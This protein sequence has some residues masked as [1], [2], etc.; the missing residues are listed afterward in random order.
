[1]RSWAGIVLGGSLSW[2]PA[3]EERVRIEGGA[4]RVFLTQDR[5]D[6]GEVHQL[7]GS[8]D[9][10]SWREAAISNA[11][12]ARY[13][14]APD[15]GVSFYRVRSRPADEASDWTNQLG[16]LD[17]RIFTESGGLPND[18][19]YA[20][21][22][23]RLDEPGRVYFQDSDRYPFH[24]DFVRARLPG[25]QDIG[26]Q[27]YERIS[28]HPEGQELLVGTV[29]RPPD[30][31]LTELGIQFTGNEPF[32]IEDVARWFDTVHSRILAPDGWRFFY[33]PAYEQSATAFD[34]EAWFAERGI[35]VDSATRW[36]TEN[37]CYSDGWALGRLKFFSAGDID[38]AFGD[39]RLTDRDIL[40]TDQ[41][42]AEIPLV[43]GVLTL[44]PATPNSH[45]AIQAKGFRIPFAHP[46]GRALQD[47]IL[48]MDGREVLLVVSVRDGQCEVRV[49]D[50]E[51]RL[52]PG[53]REAILDSKQAPDVEIVPMAP[54]GTYHLEC[55]GLTPD[56][57]GLVGG[58]AANF[59]F[60]RRSIPDHAPD[61]AI[62]LTFDLW[63]ELMAQPYGNGT[64]AES[65]AAD[66]GGFSYP[67]DVPRLRPVLEAIRSRIR[68][69]ADFD[70]P[71]RSAIIAALD[72]FD[73]DRKIRF[74]SSTNVEDS[75]VFSGAGLYD[76]SSGCL[77]DDTDGDE[78]G[79]SHCDPGAAKERGVFRAIRKVYASFYN[80]NAFIERLR[81]RIDESQVGMAVLVHHSFP[82]AI[83]LANGVA[84]L[85]IGKPADGPRIV[86]AQL[87]SQT[88]ASSITN[89]NDGFLPEVVQ[90]GYHDL[91]TGTEPSIKQHS[92]L[93]GEGESVLDGTAEYLELLELLDTA[94]RAYESWFAAEQI[95]ELDFEWKKVAPGTLVIKQIRRIPR[96][97]PVPPPVID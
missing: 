52:T 11:P 81:H 58:K 82:D 53:E 35:Q 12:F 28:L 5:M 63:N 54:A 95:L 70:A 8:A 23:A 42:P 59:G 64:L 4:S 69:A 84:T 45:V 40:V 14:L 94:A 47:Q 55:A 25:Y 87:V 66:L 85:E 19:P 61:P 37:A 31:N 65:I 34:N 76:S 29:I 60:L 2:L 3:D 18:P 44:T 73:D 26:Y 90:A 92:D 24:Y 67:P 38:A 79:P 51:G 75:T 56:D 36:I 32:P 17:G 10:V 22:T 13:G 6:D 30:P 77:A 93:L 68:E 41:V 71:E 7:E 20:K 91:P 80:E 39:G 88:G 78:A 9:L 27:D 72:G 1:M 15:D 57:I 86:T 89:P 62:A 43:A 74:R 49:Q 97:P 21:F 50:V 46:S 33:L 83:E 96:V 16:V 48:S